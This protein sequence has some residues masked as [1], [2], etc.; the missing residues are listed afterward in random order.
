MESWL[1]LRIHLVPDATVFL[2][3]SSDSKIVGKISR[4]VCLVRYPEPGEFESRGFG[5][6]NSS[7]IR[8]EGSK[9]RAMSHL[10]TIS[11]Q[12]TGK[13]SRDT[14]TSLHGNQDENLGTPPM[15]S[16]KNKPRRRSPASNSMRSS[17]ERSFGASEPESQMTSNTIGSMQSYGQKTKKRKT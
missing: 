9:M 8:L 10:P 3:S 14:L 17:A 12:R 5:D 15:Q 6:P 2:P 4:R 16:G 7:T 13:S 11:T 1:A